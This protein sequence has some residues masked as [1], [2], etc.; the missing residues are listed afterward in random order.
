M[1]CTGKQFTT[2]TWK[3][4]VLGRIK[5]HPLKGMEYYFSKTNFQKWN[6]LTLV[7]NMKLTIHQ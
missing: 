6:L 4:K 1:G 7:L 2:T 5:F 3:L